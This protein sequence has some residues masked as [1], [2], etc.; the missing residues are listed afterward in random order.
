MRLLV[1]ASR[2][3]STFVAL[4]PSTGSESADPLNQALPS[5][6][7]VSSAPARIQTILT[8]MKRSSR[9]RMRNR[10]R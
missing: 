10:L 8:P 9:I 4:A 6:S 5:F 7:S 1:C 2:C 3:G